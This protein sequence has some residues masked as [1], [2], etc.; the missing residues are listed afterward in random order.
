MI[1]IEDLKSKDTVRKALEYAESHRYE[2]PQRPIMPFLNRKHT[3]DEAKEHAKS[4]E[5]YEILMDD[6]LSMIKERRD[7]NAALDAVIE[8]YI[9]DQ[10]GLN[11]IPEQYRSK[12]YAKAE[13]D[14][15]SYGYYE[16]YNKLIDLVYLFE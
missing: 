11:S 5:L 2:M 7:H 15:H 4:M 6:Y 3:A 14:G 8:M 12:V 1:T 9:K 10:S 13:S 16:V